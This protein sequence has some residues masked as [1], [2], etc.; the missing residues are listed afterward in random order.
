M[1][2]AASRAPRYS[3]LIFGLLAAALFFV[4]FHRNSP[5]VLSLR[6][7]ADLKA[8]PALIGL[9]ASA[10]YYPYALMQLPT[11]LLAD[12]WGP[13]R[14]VSLF[15]CLAGLGSIAFGLAPTSGLAIAARVVVGLGVSVIFVSTLKF[16]TRWFRPADYALMTG[17][18]L[19]LGN[20]GG[21]FSAAPLAYL[22]Q[23]MGWR[24]ASV[25][26]GLATLVLA[27]AMGF[28]LRNRPEEV[29]LSPLAETEEA[30]LAD[31]P[32]SLAGGVKL[33]VTSARFWAGAI[34]LMAGHS[35]FFA[36]G[37][38]WGGPYLM[39]VYN[40]SQAEAGRILSFL[41]IGSI[42]G[43][44]LVSFVSDKVLFSR[45]KVIVGASVVMAGLMFIVAFFPDGLPRPA[46]YLWCLLIGLFVYAP[47]VVCMTSIKEFFPLSI[48]GTAI[49]LANGLLFLGGA[50]L[51]VLIGFILE[52]WP[53]AGSAYPP[54]A[55]SQ[56]FLVLGVSALIGL[57]AALGI[58]ETL[59]RKE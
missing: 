39:H 48:A 37:G 4:E 5:A 30:G 11:G 22:S 33:V 1:L 51:H 8:G 47:A 36:L 59:A 40:L 41:Y 32:V 56:A 31:P 12:S 57:A 43:S 25:A 17:L 15:F 35:I 6:L 24:G 34:W 46:L 29:G 54:Q 2:S 20:L 44:P 18:F 38:L 9:L 53:Q 7:M 45:K 50:A 42:T 27:L 55:Y 10:Y 28:L 21:L 23:G 26:I 49:G 58:K 13:R 14:V 16:L 52:G 3:W 19:S